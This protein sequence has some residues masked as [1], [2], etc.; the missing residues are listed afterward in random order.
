AMLKFGRDEENDADRRG[1]RNAVATGYDG[2][3]MLAFFRRLQSIEKDKPTK[4]EVYF[5]T[6]P[7][8]EGRIKRVSKEPGTA[9][10]SANEEALAE[11]LRSRSLF[12]ESADAYRRALESDPDNSNLKA[13]LAEVARLS[14]VTTPLK[15]LPQAQREEKL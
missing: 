7:P 12:R 8:T 3:A 15:P 2:E 14:P 1:L 5:L 10:T 13:R 4:F 9:V 6:H 11:G